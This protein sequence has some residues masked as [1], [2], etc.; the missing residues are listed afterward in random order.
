MTTSQYESLKRH[1]ET[2]INGYHSSLVGST[3]KADADRAILTSLVRGE[4]IGIK[5]A[6]DIREAAQRA[7]IGNNYSARTELKFADVFQLPAAVQ[8][9]Q[10]EVAKRRKVADAVRARHETIRDRVLIR[11]KA[12]AFDDKPDRVVA[13]LDD[14]DAQA[15]AVRPS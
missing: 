13:A 4:H 11:A 1:I 14:F 5:P 6:A 3:E 12:G 2:K 7:I 9:E 15:E 8:I 10:R